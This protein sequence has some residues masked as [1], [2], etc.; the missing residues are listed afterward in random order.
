MS[1]V[2][3]LD[4]AHGRVNQVEALLLNARKG[5]DELMHENRSISRQLATVTLQVSP[6]AT[7]PPQDSL[8]L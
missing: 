2:V 6:H 1:T 7:K 5:D 8:T 3:Q 4:D